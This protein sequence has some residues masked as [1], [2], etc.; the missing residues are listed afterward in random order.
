MEQT[1]VAE[2][3]NLAAEIR[4][5]ALEMRAAYGADIEHKERIKHLQE[6][7]AALFE[8]DR[9]TREALGTRTE[10]LRVGL[11][12]LQQ[13]KATSEARV[14]PMKLEAAYDKLA[15][16]DLENINDTYAFVL[17]ERGLRR[18]IPLACSVFAV[19][20]AVATLM[21]RINGATPIPIPPLGG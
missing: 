9:E 13:W 6:E 15:L 14:D 11:E 7:T 1:F 5:M 16:L 4:A 8:K 19:I 3:R 21:V 2:I 17:E 12:G 18:F 10:Q 20:I